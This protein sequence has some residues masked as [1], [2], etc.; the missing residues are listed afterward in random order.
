M[1]HAISVVI[2]TYNNA[3]FVASAVESALSQSLPPAEVIV[4]DDGST[5][6]TADV[7]APYGESI[8]YIRQSNSGPAA[9]RNRGIKAARGELIALLDAD[10]IWLPEKLQKQQDCLDANPRAGLVHSAFLRWD[11]R[12]GDT[13]LRRTVE[14]RYVGRCYHLFFFENG[15]L[16]S[17]IFVRRECVD[18]IRGF[19]ENI[20]KAGVEDYDFSLR[21]ARHYDF[22]FVDEPLVMY[23]RHE[24]NASE[25]RL[26]MLL[27]EL[28]VVTKALRDDPGLCTLVERGRFRERMRVL[29]ADIGYL[30]HVRL[31]NRDARRH[32]LKALCYCPG[33][34]HLW[35]L[36]FANLLPSPWIRELRKAKARMNGRKLSQSGLEWR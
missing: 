21:I 2:P 16:P 29:H 32:F 9:A 5:D 19:D 7:L 3:R 20:R 18:R 30:Y 14:C 36:H 8:R 15:A 25:K 28:D 26:H 23:R 11:D 6:A 31:M 34:R 24:S 33:D 12:T 4:I 13:S 17:T 27:G 22:A 1:A 35:L 10:D